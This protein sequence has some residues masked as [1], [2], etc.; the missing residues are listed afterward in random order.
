[1]IRI[2]T[3]SWTLHNTLGQARHALDE[4]GGTVCT[5]EP[6]SGALALMDLPAFVAKDGIKVLEITEYHFPHTDDVYINEF[7]SALT[8]ADVTFE[9]LLIGVGN[10]SGLDEETWQAD[11]EHNKRWQEIAAKLGAKGT[12]LDCGVDPAT[13]ETRARSST[14][15]QELA[16]YGT[17]LGLTTATENWRTTSLYPND[18]LDIMEQ[19]DQPLKLVVD[20]GNATKTGDKYGT[21]KKLMPK[22]TSLHCKGLF[23]DGELDVAEFH[24]CLSI[25]QEADF[26]GHISL[27]YDRYDD[28]WG[29]VLRLKEETQAFFNIS[30]N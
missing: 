4:Q 1:M 25:V 14:A 8:D 15:L 12:R 10:L 5:H 3:S 9:N 11:I 7:K 26:D 16:E 13:P 21:L 22:G 30:S 6:A 23:P 29:K 27:I 17:R 20:F 2:A 19:V 28:E 18:L 24:H